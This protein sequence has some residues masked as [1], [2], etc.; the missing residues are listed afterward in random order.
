[1]SPIRKDSAF[2]KAAAVFW[3]SDQSVGYAVFAE[4]EKATPPKKLSGSAITAAKSS[5]YN[6][7]GY[8]EAKLYAHAKSFSQVAQVHEAGPAY[9][10][11]SDA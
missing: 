2:L 9:R 5:G 3:Y 8:H 1:M 7:Y 4:W 6:S 10:L 11:S